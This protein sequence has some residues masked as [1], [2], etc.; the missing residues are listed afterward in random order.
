MLREKLYPQTRN[1]LE[2]YAHGAP[3]QYQRGSNTSL[4]RV[5][6]LWVMASQDVLEHEQGRRNWRDKMR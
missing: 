4:V 3:E 1:N 5:F 6:E 2:G